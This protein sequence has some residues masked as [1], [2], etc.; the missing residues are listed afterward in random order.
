M[1][2]TF[3]RSI[4]VLVMLY[5]LCL[6]TFAQGI[7]FDTSRMDRSVDACDDFF[8]FANGNWVKNTT[9]PAS[10]S[11]WGSFNILA[12]SNRDV[13]HDILENAAKAKSKKGSNAQLIGDFYASCMDEAA[14]ETAGLKPLSPYLTRINSMKSSSDVAPTI[15]WLHKNGVPVLFRLGGGPDAKNSNLVIVN[16]G[17]GGLSLPN[18]D[19]YTKMDARSVEIRV[20]FSDYMTN[21]FKL[22]GDNPDA[23][24]RNA[25]AVMDLQ[26]RLANASKPP[27]ELR[28][29]DKNYNKIPVADEQKVIPNL[30]LDSYMKTRGI[31]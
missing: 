9:I 19:Y 6:S 25:Q 22:L 27:V 5:T 17:Q 20:K 24:A 26:M 2:K 4:T 16:A 31:A 8:Q 15:A 21:M 7:A 23:A 13:L 14:I 12:E 11:R 30:P 18:K 29:R 3:F 28:D 10:Q 1:R